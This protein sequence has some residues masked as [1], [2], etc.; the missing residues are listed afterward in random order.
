MALNAT[1]LF[2][3]PYRG[4]HNAESWWTAYFTMLILWGNENDSPITLKSY[5]TDADGNLTQS[6]S[7]SFS[8]ATYGNLI[9]DAR[10]HG[11][12]FGISQWPDEYLH[13]RPDVTFLRSQEDRKVTFIETKTIGANAKGN[14]E[15]YSRLANFLVSN[16]WEV[17]LYYLLSEGHEA[18]K[19]WPAL[20]VNS[21][22]IIKWEDVFKAAAPSPLGKL[23]GVPLINYTS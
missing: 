3:K 13:L 23:F 22:S 10:L 17:E 9:A 7:V 19:D 4:F 1:Y 11:E 15:L 18:T 16:G 20:Q 12:P 8:D 6:G 5:R 21:A 2:Q 14:V